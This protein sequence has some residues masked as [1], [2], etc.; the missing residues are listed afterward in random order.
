M[1]RYSKTD[2][3]T[4]NPHH[5]DYEARRNE[6]CIERIEKQLAAA[7]HDLAHVNATI[8]LFEMNGEHSQCPVYVQMKRIFVKGELTRSA[9]RPMGQ[10]GAA[11]GSGTA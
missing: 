10:T 9:G 1:T 3:R 2:G 4:S 11:R 6:T 5:S 7:P 8:R